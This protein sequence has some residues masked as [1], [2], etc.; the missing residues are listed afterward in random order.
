MGLT[1]VADLQGKVVN[2]GLNKSM[3]I[4]LPEDIKDVLV[5]NPA[6][7]DVVVRT[8]RKIYLIGMSVGEA[9]VFLFAN[10]N[11]QLAQFELSV[12]R[13]TAALESTIA[14]SVP[15]SKIRAQSLGDS[16]VL[17]GTA[18]SAES[19][20]IAA[21]IAAKF[22]GSPEKVI[23]SVT[24]AGSDQVNLRVV[25]AEVQR[26]TARKLGVDM[27]GLA[28]VGGVTFAPI[29]A[30]SNS[31]SYNLANIANRTIG[32]QA[33]TLY[34]V[35]NGTA[36][37]AF[38]IGTSNFAAVVD[39]LKTEGVLRSLAEPNLTA[40]SGQT[41]KFL[42]GGEIPYIT[43]SGTQTTTEFRDY[44]IQLQ[45]TPVVLSSGRISLTINTEISDVD[46]TLTVN[47]GFALTKRQAQTTVEL[48]S[49]GAIALG[50]LLK[51][52]ITKA[53]SG[54][55]GLTDVPILG[56]LFK[57][58]SYKRQ[59]TELVIFVTPYLVKPVDPQEM[60]RP[61]QNL[62]FQADAQGYFLH[63]INRIY[64]ANGAAANGAY[65]GRVGF[66]YE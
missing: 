15:G 47:G 54:I 14:N 24:V 41:A 8:P 35:A 61:D 7:A 34:T 27:V 18:T 49:G 16:L 64:R 22:V 37:G 33:N 12:G 40:V 1:D 66:S 56:A 51:D 63:Q 9:N 45:F 11:R 25:V 3:I 53:S 4:D 36:N 19:V 59:Q 43:T 46:N 42:A 13:D 52:N 60:V 58:E 6:I 39:A 57:S 55:P 20:A 30:P 44:G 28:N 21:N 65:S 38:G 29:S 62:N 32:G 48:P 23:N 31:L 5:S 26:N 10:G 50:G 17:S 2:L